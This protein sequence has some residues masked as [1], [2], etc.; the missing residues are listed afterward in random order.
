V[1]LSSADLRKQQL[2]SVEAARLREAQQLTKLSDAV[3]SSLIAFEGFYPS[4]SMREKLQKTLKDCIL[5]LAKLSEEIE[6]ERALS[7]LK[8]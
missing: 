8:K 2:S 6:L 4:L 5:G 7:R 1:E 3:A